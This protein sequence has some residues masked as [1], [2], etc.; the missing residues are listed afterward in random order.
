MT[1][2]KAVV[3]NRRSTNVG[4]GHWDDWDVETEVHP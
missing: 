4:Y 3:G 1:R 2:E